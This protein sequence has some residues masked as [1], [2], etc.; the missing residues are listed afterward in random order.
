MLFNQLVAN[1]LKI[2]EVNL[3]VHGVVEENRSSNLYLESGMPRTNF[4]AL[5]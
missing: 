3:C 5:Q 1:A 4:C 2:G